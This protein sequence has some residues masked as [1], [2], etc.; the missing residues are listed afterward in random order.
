MDL[1]GNARLRNAKIIKILSVR[2]V[3][4]FANSNLSLSKWVHLIYLLSFQT[5]NQQSHAQTGVSKQSI[6]NAYACL[7]EIC[8]RYLQKKTLFVLVDPG[9]LFKSTKGVF[10]TNQNIIE[11]EHPIWLFGIVDT[12]YQPAVGYMEIVE[13]RDAETLLPIIQAVVDRKSIIHSDEWKA[14]S[15]LQGTNTVLST[16]HSNSSSRLREFTHKISS[17]TGMSRK[18]TSKKNVGLSSKHASLVFI[19]IYVERSLRKK[20]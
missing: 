15:S 4:F 14:Y 5:S 12:R 20:Q 7:R 13:K 18:R 9:L 8:D 2:N 17:L 3:S 16:I 6:T 10:S 11:E 1:L 19:R